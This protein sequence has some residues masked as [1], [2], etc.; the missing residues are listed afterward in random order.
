[1]GYMKE[2]ILEMRCWVM[3]CA[4]NETELLIA[5]EMSDNEILKFVSKWYHGGVNQ[6]EKD[7]GS[8]NTT[9]RVSA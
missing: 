9:A 7:G 5:E 2:L 6:F 4:Q 3:D 1:M 8:Q